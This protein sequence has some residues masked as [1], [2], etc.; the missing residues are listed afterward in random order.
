MPMTVEEFI[1]AEAAKPFTWGETDCAS[2]ASRWVEAV[3]GVNP[4][5]QFRRVYTNEAEAR[6]WLAEP[7]G[8]AVAMNRVMRAA[9]FAKTRTA[10][11][12]D[13]G[14]V[15]RDHRLCVSIFTGSLWFSRDASGLIGSNAFWKAWSIR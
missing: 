8:I 14:L 10:Q 13:V 15:M 11:C 1:A 6:A 5:R 12:G 7:G 3:T 9:G 2:T 4:V